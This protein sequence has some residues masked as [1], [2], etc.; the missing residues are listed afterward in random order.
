MYIADT[1]S[2]DCVSEAPAEEGEEFEV[3][4]ITSISDQ[5][6]DRLRAATISDNTLVTLR[7]CI[8]DG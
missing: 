7:Q 8:H 6:F 1:L 4:S 5:A 3:V 2:R